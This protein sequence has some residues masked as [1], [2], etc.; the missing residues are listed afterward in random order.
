MRIVG[1]TGGE[2]LHLA[3]RLPSSGV[4]LLGA[5]VAEESPCCMAIFPSRMHVSLVCLLGIWHL[6]I[7]LTPLQ[8]G[9]IP[10]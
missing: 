8:D 6:G 4:R 2:E 10:F 1:G 5:H 3:V 9:K 7:L